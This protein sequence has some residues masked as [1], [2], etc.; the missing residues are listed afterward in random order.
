MVAGCRDSCVPAL[1]RRV[2]Q[3]G[4]RT[5]QL[6]AE[7][8]KT[9]ED[10]AARLRRG[11]QRRIRFEPVPQRHKITKRHVNVPV[12]LLEQMQR[13]KESKIEQCRLLYSK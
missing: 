13:Q 1:E 2:K 3:L 5:S 7:R 8:T 9:S 10:D 12:T 6:E 11:R 4:E